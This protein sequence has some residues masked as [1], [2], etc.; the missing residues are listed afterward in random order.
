MLILKSIIKESGSVDAALAFAPQ[1]SKTTFTFIAHTGLT[2]EYSH[3][4]Q[5]PWSVFQDGPVRTI[6]TASPHK[7]GQTLDPGRIIWRRYTR[8]SLHDFNSTRNHA[9]S[10]T[11]LL[12]KH[13]STAT[14]TSPYGFPLNDFRFYLKCSFLSAFHLSFTV[15]VRY[16]SPT[17][18]QL[19]MEFTTC[20]DCTPKQSDSSETT[21]TYQRPAKDGTI[22]LSGHMFPHGL[23][24]GQYCICSS[25]LQFGLLADFRIELF[26]VHSPLLRES[27]L[28]SFPP[29]SYMLK[30][31]GSS[32]L[33]SDPK[34]KKLTGD[35][36][37]ERKS[38]TVSDNYSDGY[39]TKILPTSFEF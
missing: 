6:S 22:T 5:T 39:S 2:P 37:L 38:R 31:S 10:V 28:V 7:W 34:K 20:Q 11:V 15:L 26:P 23:D 4:C 33:I 19:Q 8:Y 29:L 35:F 12:Q 27:L 24:R 1:S 3:I 25:R 14:N 9:D 21:R 13:K 36:P 32:Y 18:I 16:R 30:F 17:I